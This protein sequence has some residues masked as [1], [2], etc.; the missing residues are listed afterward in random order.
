MSAPV[1][2]TCGN[3]DRAIGMLVTFES[4]LE[5][6]RADNMALRS[7]GDALEDELRDT[8]QRLDEAEA[9]NWDLNEE[10]I[11]MEYKIAELMDE[12]AEMDKALGDT[13]V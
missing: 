1:G 3:I 2:Y 6:L 13:T 12:I 9:R 10:I 4:A 7:W 8:S 11:K 5:D